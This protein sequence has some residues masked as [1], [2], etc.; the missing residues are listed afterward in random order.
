MKEEEKDV[1]HT[2]DLGL[3]FNLSI[4]ADEA[5]ERAAV[6]LPYLERRTESNIEIESE[7]SDDDED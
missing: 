7:D 6:N 4:T 3:S 5:K 1:D 2:K